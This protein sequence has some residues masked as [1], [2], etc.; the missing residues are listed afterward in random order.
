MSRKERR[1]LRRI[2]K[3]LRASDPRLAAML[4]HADRKVA[5]NDKSPWAPGAHPPLFLF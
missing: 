2:R 4:E 5:T 3:E 1:A